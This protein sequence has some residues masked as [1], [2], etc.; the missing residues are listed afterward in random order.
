M[1]NTG[2]LAMAMVLSLSASLYGQGTYRWQQGTSG[3]YSYRFVTNDPMGARFYTLKNGLT[4]ILSPN[5]KEPRVVFRL[6]VRSGSNSDPADHTGLA[7]YLEHLLFKG[8]NQFGSIDWSKE[9]PL[10]DEIEVLY[11]QYNSTR[12]SAARK[13]IYQK[14]DKLSY[15]ASKYAIANEYTNMMASFGSQGTNAHT[16]VEETVYEEDIPANVLDKFLSVQAERFR[17]PVIRLFHTELEAVYEEK[18]QR[19]DNDAVKVQEAMF[20]ALFPTHNY[21]VQSTIGTI[22]HLKNPSIKAI[23]DFYVKHYVPNNMAIILAGDFD[24]DA[25][26]RAIDARFGFMKPGKLEPYKGPTEAPVAGPVVKELYGPMAENMRVVF[27]IPGESSREALLCSVVQLILSNGKAGIIDVNLNKKQRVLGAGAAA[28][29]YKDYG[30]FMLMGAPK[31]SQTLEEV[32][33][34]LFE[35]IKALQ[36]GQF[37]ESLV[38]ATVA[39]L[40]LNLLQSIDDNTSRVGD[41]VDQYIKNKGDRWN[42]N[43]GYMNEVQQI[44]RREIIDFARSFFTDKNFVVIY[45]RK[46]VDSN[47][48]KV[49]KPLISP[50]ETNSGKT[51]SYVSSVVNATFAPIQPV[52]VDYKKDLKIGNVGQA[53]LLYVPNKK[54]NLFRLAYRF[55]TG[56]WSNRLLPLAGQYLQFLG[57]TGKSAEDISKQF[58]NIACSYNVN[59]SGDQTII[60]ISGLQEYFDQAVSLFEELI[61][62][63]LPDDQSLE[64]L[65]GS[66]LR[67]R[68]NIKANKMAIAEAQQFYALYGVKN[69][70]NYVLTN[71]ELNAVSAKTLTDLLHSLSGFEHRISYYGPLEM[72]ALK[73]KVIKLHPISASWKTA[74]APAE[75]KRLNIQQPEVIFSNYDAVQAEVYWV[76]NLGA[77]KAE[78][79]GIVGLYNTYFGSGMG[80]I[81]FST[82]RESKA[83]AY[84]TYAAIRT[85][86]KAQDDFSMVAYV[87]CQ[88]DKLDEAVAGMNE[89]LKDLPRLPADFTNAQQSVIKDIETDRIVEDKIISS[90]LSNRRKGVDGDVRMKNYKYYKELKLDDLF[91]YHQKNVSGRPFSYCIVASD[92]HVSIE[93]LKKYG[94][95]KVVSLEELFG[96]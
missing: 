84:S 73:L 49:D 3:G 42:V 46:G 78:Q 11:E 82:I 1:R 29:Q 91:K 48:V 35:Q 81:V 56:S 61:N 69:P 75:F 20:S 7:H 79:E 38:K 94:A 74:I 90:Y 30:L 6:A 24:A 4:V 88:A 25:T 59:V 87:G 76:R 19:S 83:L 57:M 92:K 23:K 80:S 50:I 2:L 31:Q 39:N 86:L 36:D 17:N 34:L 13:I 5:K 15:E 32:K 93:S 14:I 52:W 41:L 44:T 16:W 66:L 95:L 43:V 8:T 65:K 60:T 18:N 62:R 53:E 58:Y 27:R 71:E 37:D 85:P 21:G 12:D 55:E 28:W 54:N 9:K 63:C 72:E 77:Y 51:S 96:F 40:K 33:D 26:I 64:A 22:E 89:L 68:M 70:Y 47:V 10:L 67:S 45:K